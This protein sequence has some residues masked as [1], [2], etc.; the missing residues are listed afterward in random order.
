MIMCGGVSAALPS[1][2]GLLLEMTG[3]STRSCF[4][5]VCYCCY[6]QELM[7]DNLLQAIN[8]LSRLTELKLGCLDVDSNLALLPKQLQQM[9]LE[10]ICGDKPLVLTHLH[11]NRLRYICNTQP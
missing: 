5:V 9:Q 7:S 3:P 8:Q 1:W 2:H 10:V 11:G 4:C 6:M